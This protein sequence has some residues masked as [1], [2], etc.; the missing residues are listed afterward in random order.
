MATGRSHCCCVTTVCSWMKIKTA[1][2]FYFCR[3]V[4]LSPNESNLTKKKKK[5]RSCDEAEHS[6]SHIKALPLFPSSW[7]GRSVGGDYS[8]QA[9]V[10]EDSDHCWL[11]LLW[12]YLHTSQ[13]L[14]AKASFVASSYCS[15]QSNGI[16]MESPF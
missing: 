5:S 11:P 3:C 1:G 2:P 9:G 10:T 13:H 12:G 4:C 15:Q 6:S 8:T 16:Q 14:G 7:W